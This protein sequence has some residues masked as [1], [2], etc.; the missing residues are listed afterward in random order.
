M[1]DHLAVHQ[2]RHGDHAVALQVRLPL[3]QRRPE[4]ATSG[5]TVGVLAPLDA[6]SGHLGRPPDHR[7][8]LEVHAPGGLHF[9]IRIEHLVLLGLE[10][11][12]NDVGDLGGRQLAAAVV[13]EILP[14]LASGVAEVHGPA[15]PV[16]ERPVEQG[17]I[18]DEH[19][20]HGHIV[21][22]VGTMRCNDSAHAEGLGVVHDQLAVLAL[23]GQGQGHILPAVAVA[24]SRVL[25]ADRIQDDGLVGVTVPHLEEHIDTIG[26]EPRLH[27]TAE[28][29]LEVVVQVAG[30]DRPDLLAFLVHDPDPVR[31]LGDDEPVVLPEVE[32]QVEPA[33]HELAVVEDDLLGPG[34]ATVLVGVAIEMPATGAVTSVL[35][36]ND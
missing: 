22:T 9:E 20:R 25:A 11:V 14:D 2:D 4:R 26:Q 30:E 18:R 7:A 28:L 34:I 29:L 36:G 19:V 33:G 35:H 1:I 27:A 10:V 12:A 32:L 17:L 15:L 16:V 21:P 31:N 8:G 13:H 24:L 3:T 5:L 23:V 6:T